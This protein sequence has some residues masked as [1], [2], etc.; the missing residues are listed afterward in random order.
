[1]SSQR[2]RWPRIAD[3]ICFLLAGG[4]IERGPPADVLDRPQQPEGRRFLRRLTSAQ[5]L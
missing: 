4:I 5:H 1:M 3:E 2:T